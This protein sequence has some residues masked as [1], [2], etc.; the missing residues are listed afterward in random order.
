M[1]YGLFLVACGGAGA[2]LHNWEKKAMHSLYAG[3]GGC[4]SM[5]ICGIL[6]A[7]NIKILVA[8]GVHLA[9]VLMLVFIVVF[10]VQAFKSTGDP[11]KFDRLVLF[12][13]MGIGSAMA[14]GKAISM[15]PK[16]EKK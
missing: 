9:L 16:K 7:S 10:G 2:W 11:D 3:L 12:L 1:L 14:L 4:V 8:V 5:V 15:K 13:V 6:A